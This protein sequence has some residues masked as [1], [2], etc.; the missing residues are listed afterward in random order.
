MSPAA[1]PGGEP[2]PARRPAPTPADED[3]RQRDPAHGLTG[4]DDGRPTP[5]HG[6]RAR[7]SLARP[8]LEGGEARTARIELAVVA[9]AVALPGLV[10]GFALVGTPAPAPELPETWV[11]LAAAF[12]AALGPAAIATYLLWRAGEVRAGGLGLIAPWPFAWQTAVALLAFFAAQFAVGVVVA[13]IS[14]LLGI[15]LLDAADTPAPVL[16]P[17]YVVTGI[18]LSL[19]A[20]LGEEIVFRA[21]AITRMEDAGWPRLAIWVPNAAWALLHLYQGWRGPLVLFVMAV[22]WVYLFRWKR[23]VW[24]LVAAHAVYD[25]LVF[26]VLHPR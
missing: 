18:L 5:H 6:P 24:P 13:V 10:L 14:A 15:D 26:L 3:G 7:R 2:D 17:L 20:G 1:Y 21:Y 16:A 4:P 9:F 8:A 19:A 23:S 25:V 22:P 11:R 12:L